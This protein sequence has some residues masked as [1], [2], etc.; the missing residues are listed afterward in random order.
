MKDSFPELAFPFVYLDSSFL[1]RTNNIAAQKLTRHLLAKNP[2]RFHALLD[3]LIVAS[4][5]DYSYYESIIHL[6]QKNIISTLVTYEALN[7]ALAIHSPSLISLFGNIENVLPI[8][9]SRSSYFFDDLVLWG[10]NVKVK[11]YI[12]AAMEILNSSC[13]V[14]DDAFLSLSIGRSL[15]QYVTSDCV[16]YILKCGNQLQ[17]YGGNSVVYELP[18]NKF[19]Q[20]LH[21]QL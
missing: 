9:S 3:E 5:A 16:F 17:N 18:P 7:S 15:A 14:A 6:Q 19:I 1:H 13:V 12:A 4:K 10:E 2:Q 8:S 11:P 20:I 21:S